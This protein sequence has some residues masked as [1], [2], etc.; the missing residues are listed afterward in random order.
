MAIT[1]ETKNY[2]EFLTLVTKL[3]P[4]EFL[5]LAKMLGITLVEK[6]VDCG[7]P[8]EEQDETTGKT[9]PGFKVRAAEDILQDVAVKY[10]SLERKG[11]R[12]VMQ[13]LKTATKQKK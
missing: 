12:N 6:D 1:S 5:G 7:Q 2:T 3:E 9:K 10:M 8:V 4:T 11:R 13:L